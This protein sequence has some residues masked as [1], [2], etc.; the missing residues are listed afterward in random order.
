MINVLTT[1]ELSVYLR[2]SLSAAYRLSRNGV[3]PGRK[4]GKQWR[5][6]RSE[7]DAWLRSGGACSRRLPKK[8][9]GFVAESDVPNLTWRE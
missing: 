3:I 9:Q 1:E 4:V 2:I 8:V 6:S 7:V 5:Y